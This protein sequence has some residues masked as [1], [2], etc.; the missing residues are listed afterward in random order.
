MYAS[1]LGRYFALL[2]GC[3]AIWVGDGGAILGG[4]AAGF[5]T[6]PCREGG[7]PVACVAM[8]AGGVHPLFVGE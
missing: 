7:D 2:G 1:G 6:G 8:V 3:Q 4:F 5:D